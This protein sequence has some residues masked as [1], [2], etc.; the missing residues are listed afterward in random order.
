[1]PEATL[2]VIPIETPIQPYTDDI[3]LLRAALFGGIVPS[4]LATTALMLIQVGN[5]STY[6]LSVSLIFTFIF[7]SMYLSFFCAPFGV[8]FALFCGMLARTWLRQG[9]NLTDVQARLA[10]VGAA[11]GLVALWG[12]A[13]LLGRLFDGK[14]TV[15]SMPEWPAS[16]WAAAVVVGG[17]CGWL[18]PRL[19]RSRR[20]VASSPA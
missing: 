10:S 17:I 6:S 14:W 5:L 19:A 20:V 18:L 2:A 9:N 3:S 13:I 1:M 4:L 12:V 15:L 7:T 11:C 8:P 16:F